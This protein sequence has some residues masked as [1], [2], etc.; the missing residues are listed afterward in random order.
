MF[1]NT[2]RFICHKIYSIGRFEGLRL[3]E[4]QRKDTF[5]QAATIDETAWISSTAVI[6]NKQGL[7]EKIRVGKNSRITG[8]LIV[9][10]M[11]GEISI[12][13]YCFMGPGSRIWS[14]GKITIG[15][16]VLIAHN[17]NIHDNISHSLHSAERHEDFV[18][19]VNSGLQ[20]PF[21]IK[22][23]AIVI[24]DDV[25]IGFNA[26]IMKGVRIGKGAII[27]ANTVITKDIPPY[28]VVVGNPAKIIKY[29]D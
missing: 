25:W 5:N 22:I 27:G 21:D 29:T 26:T 24:E 7:K 13:E 10:G 19:F 4:Q 6:D 23:Q 3:Q 18:Y 15:D 17:V 14:A 11:G 8:D 28:A 20:K 1:K 16:R 12:G 9:F 2:I